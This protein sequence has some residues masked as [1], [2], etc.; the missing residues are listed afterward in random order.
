VKNWRASSGSFSRAFSATVLAGFQVIRAG[1]RGV[2][3]P[4]PDQG[5]VQFSFRLLSLLLEYDYQTG[6]DV[7]GKFDRD[8]AIADFGRQV[9]QFVKPL[10]G[11]LCFVRR[12]EWPEFAQALRQSTNRDTQIVDGLFIRMFGGATRLAA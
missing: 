7:V 10:Q 9:H 12:E 4:P 6:G 1:L 11:P 3:T 8:I 2:T 5:P